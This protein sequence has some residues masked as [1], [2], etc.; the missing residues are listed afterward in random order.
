[1]RTGNGRRQPESE[2]VR[3]TAPIMP[4]DTV[5]GRALVMVIAIMSFVAALIVGAVGLVHNAATNW[6]TD[7]VREVTIQVRPAQGRDLAA[8]I[9]KAT[10]IARRT[11]G[12]TEARALNREETA[13]LLEPWL[14]GTVDFAVL[15]LPRLIA[16][17]LAGREADLSALRATLAREVTTATLDDHR[18]WS[19]RIAA[20]SD[21][22]VIAGFAMLVLVLAATTFSVSFATRGAVAANRAVVEV[23]HLLGARDAF[24]A[25]TFQ[26]HFLAVGIKGGL[27]GGIAAAAL[28]GL[29]ALLPVLLSHVP[30]A[31]AA[32]Y[33]TGQFA[34]DPQGYA[35]I[36]GVT[37]LV[38]FATALA[39]RLTVRRTLREID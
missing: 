39:S 26:S 7:M 6:R 3:Q 33:L 31:D 17:Q 30:A 23:L 19:A 15:P 29:A 20:I 28:F 11:P 34:L 37:G 35:A 8:D 12:V 24:I 32:A 2:T 16:V 25:R 9:G 13:R 4:R 36:A 5:S 21:A 22:I 38:A 10:E 1:M 18:T 27:I 14:G